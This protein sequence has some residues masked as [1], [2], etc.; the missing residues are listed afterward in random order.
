MEIYAARFSLEIAIRDLKEEFG[1][2]DYQFQKP[3]AIRRFVHLVLFARSFWQLVLLKAKPEWLI[4][5]YGSTPIEEAPL[6]WQM[7]QR[8]MRAFILIKLFFA[9]T[10]LRSSE[11]RVHS[12][13][14]RKRCGLG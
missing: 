2:A 13:E 14:V 10:K 3:L 7:A 6:S 11:V 8:K 9:S 5:R 1:L 4:R 12:P